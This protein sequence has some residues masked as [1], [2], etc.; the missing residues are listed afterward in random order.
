[1]RVQELFLVAGIL[2]VLLQG[3]LSCG[4]SLFSLIAVLYY[5]CN[6]ISLCKN[7]T[8]SDLDVTP[9]CL[10]PLLIILNLIDISPLRGLFT[11]VIMESGTCDSP[12]FVHKLDEALSWSQVFATSIGCN[13]T[14]ST[15]QMSCMRAL[16]TSQIMGQA[17]NSL[18]IDIAQR[19][20]GFLP[21]LFPVFSWGCAI[22]GV[23]LTDLP[24]EIIR[25]GN[26]NRASVIMGTNLDE[27]SL[28]V[29]MTGFILPVHWPMTNDVCR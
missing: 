11:S 26:H 28:F 8:L 22:D 14:D 18:V 25:K 19:T 27:G 12:Q 7:A 6:I 29:P 3:E 10:S 13:Q 21:V 20:G 2:L 1:V 17:N 16:P 9:T 24:L 4:F 5:E 23:A 15:D